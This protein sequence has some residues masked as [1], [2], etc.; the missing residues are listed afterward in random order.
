[1]Q[2]TKPKPPVLPTQYG[3][4]AAVSSAIVMFNYGPPNQRNC[5]SKPIKYQPPL[6]SVTPSLDGTISDLAWSPDGKTVAAV[7]ERG[8]SLYDHLGSAVDFIDPPNSNELIRACSFGWKSSRYLYFG[9]SDRIVHVWDRKDSKLVSST[10]VR[11]MQ[12]HVSETLESI[13][14]THIVC[15]QPLDSSV[16]CIALSADDG[17]LAVG[18]VSG[19]LLVQSLKHNTSGKL[20][21]PF[22]ASV[23]QLAFYPFKKSVMAAASDDGT[24]ALWDVN[25]KTD[26]FQVKKGA[27]SAPIQGLAFAPCNKNF[28]CTVGLDKQLR[29]HDIQQ[30]SSSSILQSYEADGPLMSVSI[31][32]DHIVAIGTSNGTVLVY[33][34]RMKAVIHKFDT[35]TEQSVS[36]IRFQPPRWAIDVASK[37]PAIL[38]KNIQSAPHDQRK[39]STKPAISFEDPMAMFSPVNN[40]KVSKRHS[41]DLRK[42]LLKTNAFSGSL[43]SVSDKSQ[44]KELKQSSDIAH[45]VSSNEKPIS[46]MQSTQMHDDESPFV[47]P[48]T[49]KSALSTNNRAGHL[50]E[51]PKPDFKIEQLP[52]EDSALDSTTLDYSK[53]PTAAFSTRTLNSALSSAATSVVSAYPVASAENPDRP[54]IPPPLSVDADSILTT[55]P[56]S[57]YS[58]M[59]NRLTL[60]ATD[61]ALSSYTASSTTSTVRTHAGLTSKLP[62]DFTEAPQ[63][64]EIIPSVVDELVKNDVAIN[65]DSIA[66]HMGLSTSHE[67]KP[68]FTAVSKVPDGS[69]SIDNTSI[70]YRL[71]RSVVEECLHEHRQQT[72]A[73]IQN[74]H[75]ELIRQFQLQEGYISELLQCESPM[76]SMMKELAQLRL[77][78]QQL[79]NLLAR[80][81]DSI[82]LQTHLG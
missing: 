14:V 35:L 12:Y 42:A 1:M 45:S 30:S 49:D 66:K 19:S 60:T 17:K 22:V 20:S 6:L 67:T 47:V 38:P 62:L 69:L 53:T 13:N 16:N 55:T 39:D 4:A 63:Q 65:T 58:N 31:N 34:V 48:T 79:R 71:L 9:G 82:T 75:L 46:R 54:I 73:N 32:D 41:Q 56:A 29:F 43:N 26:P 76:A 36:R 40:N 27:H 44:I 52:F 68:A 21:T 50:H 64:R 24:V 2:K 80:S 77:E 25:H 57:N 11:S 15:V 28:Y 51:N 7:T 78:N 70:Q 37:E 33:D 5:L 74:M 8:I 23:N 61:P 18:S 72:R 59:T 10:A 81:P 3:L